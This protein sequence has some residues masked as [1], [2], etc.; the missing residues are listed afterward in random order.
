VV[1]TADRL[2]ALVVGRAAVGVSWLMLPDAE[3]LGKLRSALSPFPCVVFDA[4]G[5]ARQGIDP[6]GPADEGGLR[7]MRRVKERFDPAGVLNP[8]IFVGG[9]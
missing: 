7:L 5:D 4:P 8:G 6:W 9:I 2:G 3:P 1:R